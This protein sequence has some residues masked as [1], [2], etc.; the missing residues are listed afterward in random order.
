[1]LSTGSCSWYLLSSCACL[2]LFSANYS[3]KII[4]GNQLKPRM[5]LSSSRGH[6]CLKQAGHH[7]APLVWA[8]PEPLPSDFELGAS[9]AL[10]P[11]LSPRGLFT[12]V[13]GRLPQAWYHLRSCLWKAVGFDFPSSC[14]L[15]LLRQKFCSLLTSS[16]LYWLNFSLTII[17]LAFSF[18]LFAL[19]I[20]SRDTSPLSYMP[21]PFDF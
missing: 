1:M 9:W 19:G 5:K 10:Q 6:S 13:C 4:C 15:N 20:E 11:G 8:S 16:L 18:F 3:W 2:S 21:S 7:E 12:S 17:L 14:L